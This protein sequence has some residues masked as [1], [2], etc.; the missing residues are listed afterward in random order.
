MDFLVQ[1]SLE[2]VALNAFDCKKLKDIEMDGFE[3][4]DS[5]LRNIGDVVLRYGLRRPP[6]PDSTKTT[7]GPPVVAVDFY[8]QR[9]SRLCQPL[10][11]KNNTEQAT[12]SV[13]NTVSL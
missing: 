8:S 5:F 2:L 11:T 1:M 12:T 6:P 10:R 4:P 7:C 3:S 13:R 9:M